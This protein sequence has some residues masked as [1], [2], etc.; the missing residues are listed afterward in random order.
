[1][2]HII[3][4]IASLLLLATVR[5]QNAETLAHQADE[6]YRH[7][8]YDS[9]LV[10][11]Q[12]AIQSGHSSADLH[13]NLANTH[14]RLGQL[15]QAILHYER[16]LRLKPGMDDAQENL[17]LANS[18]TQDRI[19]QLPQFFLVNW[20]TALCTH[21]T[22][23]SWRII[24]LLLFALLAAAIATFLL[25]NNLPLRKGTFTAA[26]ITA[27]L[28][29]TTTFILLSSTR[30]FNAHSEA[31]VIQQAISVK[32]SP[33]HQSIDKLILHEGTKV[34][35]TETLPGWNKITLADG[36]TGWCEDRNIERI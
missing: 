29:L 16:A 4:L 24:W 17:T 15:G 21:I 30:H 35:I 22:P 19:T 12:S 28:L 23:K 36:T 34:T 14:Y 3:S 8:Q 7:G 9:A 25:A 20:Y 31:I 27:S 6:L 2:K 13:Y 33:E 32:G 11:Y 1:M 10:L 26:I 5:G 18:K